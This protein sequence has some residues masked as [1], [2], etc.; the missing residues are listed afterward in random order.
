MCYKMIL[1]CFY[2]QLYILLVLFCFFVFLYLFSNFITVLGLFKF[3]SLSVVELS[4][5]IN[6][7][8]TCLY[9]FPVPAKV[10]DP[11]ED[12][13]LSLHQHF[14]IHQTTCVSKLHLKEIFAKTTLAA[15]VTNALFELCSDV[16]KGR[17]N[18]LQGVHMLSMVLRTTPWSK[19]SSY[20]FDVGDGGC[21][22]CY[23]SSCAFF[24]SSTIF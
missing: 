15:S 2:L 3:Y 12:Y 23:C 1:V 17:Q 16:I 22:G 20:T 4:S 11:V 13:M 18:L 10:S 19:S 6:D 14:S 9:Q 8:V 5:C 21:F 7:C 24:L